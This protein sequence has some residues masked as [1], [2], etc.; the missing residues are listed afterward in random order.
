MT[1][2]EPTNPMMEDMQQMKR[3]RSITAAAVSND[4]GGQAAEAEW[5]KHLKPIEKAPYETN[6]NNQK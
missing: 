5:R 4:V 2:Q 6:I 3:N 1:K